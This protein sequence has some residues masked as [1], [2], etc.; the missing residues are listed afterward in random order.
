MIATGQLIL[1]LSI[2]VLLHELGHFIPAKLFKMRV[3]KF[4]LFFNPWFSVFKVRKGETEY[5]LGWLPLGG[6]VKIAGMID[7][8]MDKAAMD[9]PPQPWEFRSKPAWQRLITMLG[10]IFVNLVLGFVIFVGIYTYYGEKYLPVTSL[11]WGVYADPI[12]REIG[13][14]NGD[15]FFSVDGVELTRNDDL[16][17]LCYKTILGETKTITVLRGKEKVEIKIPEDITN[18]LMANK[19]LSIFDVP[20]PF[21]I[22]SIVPNGNAYLAGLQKHDRIIGVNNIPTF[23]FHQV[24]EQLKANKS[25]FVK[26]QIDRHGFKRTLS[27]FVDKNGIIGV[28]TNV[29]D[30]DRY[31]TEIKKFTLLQSIKKSASH[32]FTTFIRNATQL[33]AVFNPNGVKHVGSVLSMRKQFGEEWNWHKFW[34]L[35]ANLSLILAF[36][37]LLPI[38]GLDGGHAIFTIYEIITRR[39]PSKKFMEVTQTIGMVLLLSLMFFALGNDIYNGNY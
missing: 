3:D 17:E 26:L 21:I 27:S 20:F 28:K 14:K 18:R 29:D 13:F 35:T 38:P 1:A 32:T 33:K 9:L 30:L 4:Y 16:G 23:S 11:K 10:G 19:E 25:K 7:E 24:T 12:M 8:S 15:K 34:L 22:D 37:N 6:Y 31:D 2:L 39:K 36:F 5:G